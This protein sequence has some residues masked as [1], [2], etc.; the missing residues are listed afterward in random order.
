MSAT[1]LPP[2][3]P[4]SPV[5]RGR[6]GGDPRYG[7]Y[8]VPRRYRLHLS[9]TSADCLTIAVTHAVL[10]L[11]DTVPVAVLP[12]RPDRQDDGYRDLEDLYEASSHLHPGPTAAPALSDS[13]AG[14]IVSTYAPEIV[15]DLAARF[16]GEHPDFRPRRTEDELRT[17][18][19]LTDDGMAA[20]A[21]CAS[22]PGTVARSAAAPLLEALAT[23]EQR[24]ADREFLGGTA[25]GAADV[26]VWAGLVMLDTVH[27]PHMA[28]D[29]AA[30]VAAHP[31]VWTYARGLAGLP[32][33]GA[34]PDL[35]GIAARY[36]ERCRTDRRPC[37]RDPLIPPAA[38]AGT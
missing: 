19:R 21:A 4:S 22:W 34:Q 3:P 16:G 10:G 6:I 28:Q 1:A 13:W 14:R 12:A 23:L 37:R 26:H 31:R 8:P 27:R 15:R 7:H 38:Y 30:D 35:D 9:R 18:T 20:A 29:L 17:L 11:G 24:L 32:A 36:H 25:V 5:I 2:A 33:F